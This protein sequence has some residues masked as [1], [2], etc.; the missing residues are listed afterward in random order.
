MRKTITM[1]L[2]CLIIITATGCGK[3]EVQ[4]SAPSQALTMGNPWKSFETMKEAEEAVGFSFGLSENILESYQAVSFRAMNGELMEVLYQNGDFEVCVRKKVGAGE[5]ISGDYN[6]YD[7]TSETKVNDATITYYRNE[8]TPAQR[9]V[10]SYQE[11][12][13]SL[14]APNGYPEGDDLAILDLILVE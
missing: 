1:L 14:V 12:S 11:F 5:D 6:K 13:W 7:T 9:H 3:T 10:I 4:E 8:K 2:F